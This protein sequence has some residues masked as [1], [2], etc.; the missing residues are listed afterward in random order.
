MSLSAS[1][2]FFLDKPPVL[3]FA[4]DRGNHFLDQQFATWMIQALRRA[5][6]RPLKGGFLGFEGFLKDI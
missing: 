6:G 5:I 1:A 4:G 2:L 3:A